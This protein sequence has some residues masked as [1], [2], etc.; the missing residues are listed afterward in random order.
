MIAPFATSERGQRRNLAESERLAGHSEVG[1]LEGYLLDEVVVARQDQQTRVE[2]HA[3]LLRDD[4]RFRLFQIDPD[5]YFEFNA[6]FPHCFAC[7]RE[8][9]LEAGKRPRLIDERGAVGG[10]AAALSSGQT[11]ATS[12]QLLQWNG[13][14]IE[15]ELETIRS[16]SRNVSKRA[17]PRVDERLSRRDMSDSQRSASLNGVESSYLVACQ[18]G[19]VSDEQEDKVL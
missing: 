16:S 18:D 13:V 3:S 10:F 4:R 8:I 6:M 17:D 9:D 11:L 7:D 19:T 2:I 1:Q 15:D 14:P 12:K 5:L